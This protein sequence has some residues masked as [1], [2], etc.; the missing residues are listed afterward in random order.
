M[1][2]DIAFRYIHFK[3]KHTLILEWFGKTQEVVSLQKPLSSKSMHVKAS[4][5]IGKEKLSKFNSVFAKRFYNEH[6]YQ[7]HIF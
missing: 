5:T 4:T 1:E 2:T 6:Q 3:V 7:Q